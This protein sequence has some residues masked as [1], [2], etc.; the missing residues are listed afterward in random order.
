MWEIHKNIL[1]DIFPWACPKHREICTVTDWNPLSGRHTARVM[2]QDDTR[3]AVTERHSRQIH[4]HLHCHVTRTQKC[5]IRHTTKT[6][7]RY[8][9]HQ[10]CSV[11][12]RLVLFQKWDPE[13]V[14][15]RHRHSRHTCTAPKTY[16][17]LCDRATDRQYHKNRHG[18]TQSLARSLSHTHKSRH[19]ALSLKLS[20]NSYPESVTVIQTDIHPPYRKETTDALSQTDPRRHALVSETDT[21]CQRLSPT[22][23][24]HL[25]H[26]E[27]SPHLTH[28]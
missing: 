23:S 11:T 10:T 2:S 27:T 13:S 28:N 24:P 6:C 15:G 20:R 17:Y 12:E 19:A 5:P 7:H 1:P 22:R 14:T 9:Y 4:I 3:D 26:L 8:L 16:I 18:T 21:N 25:T